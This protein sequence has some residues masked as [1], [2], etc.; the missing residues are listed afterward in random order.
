MLK[1]VIEW[2][3][4]LAIFGVAALI[5]NWFGMDVLPWEAIPG[6]LV[7]IAV[8]LVGLMLEKALPF[9]MPALCRM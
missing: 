4:V 9:S 1:S 7:L 2:T 8:S 3:W 6:M 5:G